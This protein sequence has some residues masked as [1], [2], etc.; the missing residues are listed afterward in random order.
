MSDIHDFN[1]RVIAG[2][3]AN[4]GAVGGD[5][6]GATILLLTT[7]GATPGLEQVSPTVCRVEGDDAYVVASK[8]GAPTN[9]D[10]YHNPVANPE[11][12]VELGTDSYAVRAAVIEGAERDRIYQARAEQYPGCAEYETLVGGARVIPVVRLDRIRPDPPAGPSPHGTAGRSTVVPMTSPAGI[13]RCA[14]CQRPIDRRPGA[15]RPRLF[16]SASHRQRA[17]EARRRADE[18]HVPAGQIVVSTADLARLHDLLYRLE[19][20]V[21]DVTADLAATA[22]PGAYRDAYE[23]LMDAVADLVGTV[24]EPVRR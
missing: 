14:W 4:G 9:P 18:L 17:Y 19:T 5:F 24:I 23:H 12:T 11:V 13:E 21:E 22:D 8:A 2:F 15:G 16:C 3:R 20:A 6:A 7:T 1:A 10:C